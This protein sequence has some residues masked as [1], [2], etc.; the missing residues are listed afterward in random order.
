LHF[1]LAFIGFG[2]VGQGLLEILVRKREWLKKEYKFE[3]NLV[4]ISDIMKGSKYNPEGLNAQN[5]LSEVK[6]K[7][8]IKDTNNKIKGNITYSL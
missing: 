6:S 7:R 3:W 8:N 1:N 4:A 5:C 2:V